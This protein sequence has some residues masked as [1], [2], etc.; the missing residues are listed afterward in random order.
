[1]GLVSTLVHQCEVVPVK[2]LQLQV[3]VEVLV[4]GDFVQPCVDHAAQNPAQFCEEIKDYSVTY[5]EHIATFEVP[6]Q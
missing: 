1:M 6:Y 4:G 5:C 3:S 2:V